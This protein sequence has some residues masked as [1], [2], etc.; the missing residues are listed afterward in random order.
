MT[1]EA[2]QLWAK[3]GSAVLLG[4]ALFCGIWIVFCLNRKKSNTYY[5]RDLVMVNGKANLDKHILVAMAVVSLWVV[6]VKTTG[7]YKGEDV[8]GLLSIVLGTFVAK[9]LGDNWID[10]KRGPRSETTIVSRTQERSPLDP[11][12]APDGGKQ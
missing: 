12:C 11:D 3:Y 6:V 1:G 7:V 10:S 8:T 4:L 2:L 9:R 5:A